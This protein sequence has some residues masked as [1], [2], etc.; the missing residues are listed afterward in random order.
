MTLLRFIAAVRARG[1]DVGLVALTGS[2]RLLAQKMYL[3]RFVEIFN[4]VEEACRSLAPGA[5][6]QEDHLEHA[7]A[8]AEHRPVHQVSRSES[9]SQEILQ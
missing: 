2:V 5:L 8:L 1:G 9:A 4:T 3:H 7:L 6:S